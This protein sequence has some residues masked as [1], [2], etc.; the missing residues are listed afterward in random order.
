MIFP[1]PRLIRQEPF[2]PD[3]LS[4]NVP[5]IRATGA[6]WI[7]APPWIGARAWCRP[8]LIGKHMTEL[9]LTALAAARVVRAFHR[10]LPSN[11]T[12][13]CQLTQRFPT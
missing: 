5:F 2:E 1:S 13:R 7:G 12:G 10:R 11:V 6:P 9:M 4:G 8:P 3:E